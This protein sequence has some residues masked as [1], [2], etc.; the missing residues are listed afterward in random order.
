[1]FYK[2]LAQAQSDEEVD[3][4]RGELRDLC[5]DPPDEVDALFELTSLRIAMRR[6]RLRSLENGPGR[7]VVSLG[8]DAA[9]SP[10]KLAAKIT[11]ARGDW[12]LTPDM[13]LVVSKPKAG[14]ELSE[15][16]RLVHELSLLAS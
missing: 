1:L 2:R 3:D 16:K 10:E 9:I 15:A 6:L 7:L 14:Q 4:I 12:K 5:G 11:R 13:K 8:A